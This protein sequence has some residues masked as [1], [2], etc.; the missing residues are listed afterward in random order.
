MKIIHLAAVA[1]ACSFLCACGGSDGGGG[2]DAPPGATMYVQ[3]V[4][5]LGS[6]DTFVT[7]DVDDQDNTI[8]SGYEDSV[9]AVDA[10]GSYQLSRDDP[11]NRTVTVDGITY[12]YSPTVFQFGDASTN[13][14]I[15]TGYTYA[16]PSGGTVTCS[17][18]VRSGGHAQ[19]WYV[20][21]AWTMAY[22]VTCGTTTTAYVESGSVDGVEAVT[23]PAGTFTALKLSSSLAWSTASG[24][25]VVEHVT[26]WVDP[27]HSLFALKRTIAYQRSGNVPAHFLVGFTTE[28]QS[29]H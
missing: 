21:Q 5:T 18:A 20:G 8:N 4:P 2:N 24:Q 15:E 25:D 28:L 23:V 6:L 9:T 22:D 13:R 12:H 16:P 27:A 1:A 26:S 14:G 17:V 19:P 3:A 29:R 11:S 7:A 10:D